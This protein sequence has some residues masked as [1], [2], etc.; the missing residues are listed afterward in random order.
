MKFTIT[1]ALI[2]LLPNVEWTITDNDLSTLII[3]SE[4]NYKIPNEIDVENAIIELQAEFL[5]NE[6]KKSAA[7]SA[8]LERLGITEEEAKLLLS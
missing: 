8:L 2:K 7:K 6:Q 3:H 5:A 1:D 4:G